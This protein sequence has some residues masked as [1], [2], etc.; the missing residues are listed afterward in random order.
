MPNLQRPTPNRLKYC[1]G[2]DSNSRPTPNAFGAALLL[3]MID[4]DGRILLCFQCAFNSPRFLECWH[5]LAYDHFDSV[6]K[7][8]GC[9]C[10]TS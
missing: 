6:A 4:R 1:Q 3:Q 9:V 8:F 5:L 2:G 7:P 10:M